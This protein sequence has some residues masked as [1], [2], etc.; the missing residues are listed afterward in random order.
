MAGGVKT[1]DY[2]Q[3]T[4]IP[5]LYIVGDATRD[6]VRDCRRNEAAETACAISKA[7][8]KADNLL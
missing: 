7:L 3:S 4:T 2:G 5:G 6:S 8:W 1:G